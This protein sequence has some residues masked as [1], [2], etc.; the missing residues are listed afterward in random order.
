[1]RCPAIFGV[2]ILV[3]DI[4]QSLAFQTEVLGTDVIYAVPDF[5][6]IRLQGADGSTHEWMLHADH[7]FG[8][9]L[10]MADPGWRGLR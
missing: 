3:R 8:D 5:A 6:V 10:P 4:D 1:M 7:S 9:H 2:N